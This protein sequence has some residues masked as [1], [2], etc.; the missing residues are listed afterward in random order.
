MSIIDSISEVKEK[1][2]MLIWDGIMEFM[3]QIIHIHAVEFAV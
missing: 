1:V 3:L 2:K